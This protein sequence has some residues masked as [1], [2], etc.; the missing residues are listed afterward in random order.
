MIKRLTKDEEAYFLRVGH[1]KGE[2]N[3]LERAMSVVRCEIK[4][5][6]D[7]WVRIARNKAREILG[8]ETYLSGISRS[9]F[10]SSA[11]REKDGQSIYYLTQNTR[12]FSHEMNATYII[13]KV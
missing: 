13:S 9:A 2:L 8:D 11:V 7:K 3:Q 6:N 4:K 12:D 5:P 10:H 1:P